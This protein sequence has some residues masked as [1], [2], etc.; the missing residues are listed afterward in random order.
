EYITFSASYIPPGEEKIRRVGLATRAFPGSHT[1]VDVECWIEKITREWFAP[2]MGDRVLTKDVFIA[3]T[4]DQGANVVNAIEALGVIV[5]LC[6][7]HR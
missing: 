1:A 6:C 3:L 4:V 2:M 7:A 5:V